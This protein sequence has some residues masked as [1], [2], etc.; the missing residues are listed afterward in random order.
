MK[1][2]ADGS[3]SSN[4]TV[5]VMLVKD[6]SHLCLFATRDIVP[7]MELTVTC[8]SVLLLK[9]ICTSQTSKYVFGVFTYLSYRFHTHM[10]NR[11]A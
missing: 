3:T 5:K 11:G 2:V 8:S 10:N 6:K 1:M 7:G 4:F 9:G